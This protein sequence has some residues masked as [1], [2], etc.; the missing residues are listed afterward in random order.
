MRPLPPQM[1]EIITSMQ[2]FTA[3]SA[4]IFHH[5]RHGDG[6][7]VDISMERTGLWCVVLTTQSPPPLAPFAPAPSPAPSTPPNPLSQW[8][9]PYPC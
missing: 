2:A 7:I 8:P 3:V 4:A 6:Q 9:N 1:G 5:K